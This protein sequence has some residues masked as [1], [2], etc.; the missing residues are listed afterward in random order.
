MKPIDKRRR[1]GSEMENYTRVGKREDE[2]GRDERDRWESYLLVLRKTQYL[3][4]NRCFLAPQPEQLSIGLLPLISSFIRIRNFCQDTHKPGH[5]LLHQPPWH[6]IPLKLQI[7][8]TRSPRL[9]TSSDRTLLVLCKPY[10][11]CGLEHHHLLSELRSPG[12]NLAAPKK[13]MAPGALSFSPWTVPKARL[14]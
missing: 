10:P 2:A 11:N 1:D 12:P 8:R 7:G 14:G 9:P 3:R 13:R 6:K 5:V 4:L